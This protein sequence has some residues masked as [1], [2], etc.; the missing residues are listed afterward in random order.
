MFVG[1]FVVVGISSESSFSFVVIVIVTEIVE[2]SISEDD[3]DPLIAMFEDV[4]FNSVNTGTKDGVVIVG[5]E[6]LLGDCVV[7]SIKSDAF[8]N[9]WVK[10][11]VESGAI[12][13]FNMG[14]WGDDIS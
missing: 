8:V 7:E 13:G 9:S 1:F 10:V 4:V 3:K 14:C 12:V 5:I 6:E 2:E 11:D